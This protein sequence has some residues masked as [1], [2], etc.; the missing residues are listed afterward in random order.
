MKKEFLRR[1][2]TIE[3]KGYGPGDKFYDDTQK[4]KDQ[5]KIIKA[6]LDK[7]V[8][9]KRQ[10]GKMNQPGAGGDYRKTNGR[11]WW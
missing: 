1:E 10:V 6:S 11:R 8:T 2:K 4:M 5:L 7:N 3:K 9:T